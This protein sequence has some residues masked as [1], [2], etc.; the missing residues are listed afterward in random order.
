RARESRPSEDPA[1]P[2]PPP[3]TDGAPS[4]PP[5]QDKPN[6]FLGGKS[7]RPESDGAGEGGGLRRRGA[8]GAMIAR[9]ANVVPTIAPPSLLAGIDGKVGVVTKIGDAGGPFVYRAE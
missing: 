6:A 2:P 7:P 9:L 8:A 1:A 3:A 4:E 5:K